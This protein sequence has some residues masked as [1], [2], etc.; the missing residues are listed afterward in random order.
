MVS[1][2]TNTFTNLCRNTKNT[3]VFISIKI[4]VLWK[5]ILKTIM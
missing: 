2:K 1:I 3:L 4:K 5:N